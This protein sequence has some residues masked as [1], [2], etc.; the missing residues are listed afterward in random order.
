MIETLSE[1]RA[2]NRTELVLYLNA[3][4]YQ[5]YDWETTEELRHAAELNAR[6]EGAST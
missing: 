3:W 5:C 6:C 1:I 2:A 4:G